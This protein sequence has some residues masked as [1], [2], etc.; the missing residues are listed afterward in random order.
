MRN[1][2]TLGFILLATLA[3][4]AQPGKNIQA[5]KVSYITKQ[6]DLSPEEAQQF[7]PVYNEYQDKLS[8]IQK[9]KR[10]EMIENRMNFDDLSDVDVQKAIDKQFDFEQQELDLKK[11]YYTRFEK[12]LPVKKVA[13]L[14]VAE[15]RF[16]V[17]LLKQ[18]QERRQ[19][20]GGNGW[21]NR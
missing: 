1:F 4:F 17:W 19:G 14:M 18:I 12:V 5:L 10:Q 21:H 11:E 7:W 3:G 13:K 6:L 15:E 8:A 9:S 2:F 16:K 20:N